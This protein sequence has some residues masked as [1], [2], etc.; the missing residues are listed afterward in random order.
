M[1]PI[2]A[3]Y[4]EQQLG[5]LLRH[6]RPQTPQTPF[7]FKPRFLAVTEIEKRQLTLYSLSFCTDSRLAETATLDSG[8]IRRF[9][10]PRKNTYTLK[11]RM[12]FESFLGFC[13]YINSLVGSEV[14][15]C[16]GGGEGVTLTLTRGECTACEEGLCDYTIELLEENL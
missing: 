14:S 11:G 5:K 4:S 10:G 13:E 8:I 6:Q 1:F 2:P 15:L 9:A 12:P 7:L 3:A 16:V